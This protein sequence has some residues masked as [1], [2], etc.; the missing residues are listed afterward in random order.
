MVF[1]TERLR[2]A[3]QHTVAHMPLILQRQ[4]VVPNALEDAS[5]RCFCLQRCCLA[6]RAALRATCHSCNGLL[7][8]ELVRVLLQLVESELPARAQTCCSE[9]S[10]FPG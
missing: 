4:L 1:K 8:T 3:E 6:I 7:V 5:V 9:R 10:G 2:N